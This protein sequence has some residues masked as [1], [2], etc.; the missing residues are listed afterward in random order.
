MKWN[1]SKRAHGR[2]VAHDVAENLATLAAIE[3]R[4]DAVSRNNTQGTAFRIIGNWLIREKILWDY[5]RHRSPQKICG[6]P[7]FIPSFPVRNAIK[8]LYYL[9]FGTRIR[10]DLSASAVIFKSNMR[11]FYFQQKMT[12]WVA[13]Q[14][15]STEK[16]DESMT[17]RNRFA[18]ISGF[19][20][21]QVIEQDT[22]AKPPFIFEE[23]ACGRRL[24]ETNDWKVF[25][26]QVLPLL[27]RF[28]DH[29]SIRHRR[30]ADVYNTDWISSKIAGLISELKWKKK[31]APLPRFLK[32]TEECLSLRDETIP[33]CIGH[34]DLA[35]NNFVVSENGNFALLDWEVSRELPMARELIKLVFQHPSLLY[36]L[37]PEIRSRT[38]DP[39]A[40]PPR[41]QFLC[42]ALDTI[43]GFENFQAGRPPGTKKIKQWFGLASMLIAGPD[44]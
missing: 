22:A 18:Q 4:L 30:A 39:I 6:V 41:R 2:I 32:A 19:L 34:G 40:M 23:L 21:P 10:A 13:R 43:A 11:S 35:K 16:L 24:G 3:A 38:E 8:A 42:A 12:L 26:D 15:R 17:A 1:I 27:F 7:N 20:Q 14:Q 5:L 25:P 44:W 29:G 37:E 33:L 28:Y 31:W 36:C 9:V